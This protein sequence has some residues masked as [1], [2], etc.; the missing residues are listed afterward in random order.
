MEPRKK[1][2]LKIKTLKT[3]YI[4]HEF[5]KHILQSVMRNFSANEGSRVHAHIKLTRIAKK[6][7]ISRQRNVCRMSG[8]NKGIYKPFGLSRHF[9]KSMGK[10]S[11]LTNLRIKSW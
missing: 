9:I 11:K 8:K 4:K 2:I 3:N 6:N 10:M 5:K 1:R 7:W